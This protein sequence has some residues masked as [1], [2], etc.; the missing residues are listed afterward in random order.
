M[1]EVTILEYN[2]TWTYEFEEE[3]VKIF[4]ALND[5]QVVIEHIGSTSVSG[6]GSKPTID[7]MAGIPRLDL[8]DETYIRKLNDIGYEYVNKPEFSERLFF[9]R[10]L[11]R[12]GT[13]HLHIY[14]YQ[15]DNWNENLLFREYLKR[16]PE[17]MNEYYK[18]KKNLEEQFKHDRVA[19]T[20]GKADF[21]K[22]I[23]NKA[24]NDKELRRFLEE[25]NSI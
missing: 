9:R 1:E 21:I 11:W 25:G 6:L 4:N 24:I 10:G 16:N 7:I 8:I 12:A 2:P 19:Y 5:L 15:G 3:R 23:I 18:L 17:T 14:R 20:M 22:G 13:H